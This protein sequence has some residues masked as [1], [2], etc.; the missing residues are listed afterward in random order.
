MLVEEVR[1][2][3]IKENAA[4]SR[5]HKAEKR[6][7]LLRKCR[8]LTTMLK[9]KGRQSLEKKVAEVK[10]VR[11]REEMLAALRAQIFNHKMC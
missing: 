2:L 11:M 9:H 4:R 8:E 3:G 10:E 7:E 6:A 5:R 1:K